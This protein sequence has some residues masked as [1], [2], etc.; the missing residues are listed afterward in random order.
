MEMPTC[1]KD[2]CPGHREHDLLPMGDF[3]DENETYTNKEFYIFTS[4]H[5]DLLPY[6]YDSF[7]Y[8]PACSAANLTWFDDDDFVDDDDGS[9]G[10]S[11]TG[12]GGKHSGKHSSSGGGGKHG[13]SSK[14]GHGSLW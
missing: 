10:K 1:Y 3:L 4:P 2:V 14:S 12:G 11:S 13:G 9:N 5:N 6:V 8:W 7:D